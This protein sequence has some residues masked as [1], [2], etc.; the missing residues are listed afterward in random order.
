MHAYSMNRGQLDQVQTSLDGLSGSITLGNA[1]SGRRAGWVLAVEL[2]ILL[3]VVVDMKAEL[4]RVNVPVAPDEERAKDWLSQ[5]IK[6]AVEDGLRIGSDDVGT[7]TDTPRDRVKGPEERSERATDKESAAN[8]LAHS[9]GVLASLPG[10][11]V[12]DE[13]ECNAAEGEVTPLVDSTDQ[14][15]NKTS[16]DHDL[17]DEDHIHDGGPRHTS[18]EKKIHEQ[19]RGGD[20]PVDVANVEDLA[21]QSGNL[22]VAALEFDHYASP[23]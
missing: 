2:S 23:S 4:G 18:C 14:G 8:V 21:V 13:E 15:A 17:I 9:V 5:D 6:D 20:E 12:N 3:I 7:L 19:E 1:I 22:R 11:H 10:E 16:H